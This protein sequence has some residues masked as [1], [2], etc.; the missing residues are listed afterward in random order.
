MVSKLPLKTNSNKYIGNSLY[1]GDNLIEN[2]YAEETQSWIRDLCR[3][4]L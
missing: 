2:K 4:C 1:V 3:G